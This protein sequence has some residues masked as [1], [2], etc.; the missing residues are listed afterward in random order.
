MEE[1]YHLTYELTPHPEGITKED[2]P[3]GHGA[4]DAAILCSIMYPPDG[5]YSLLLLPADGRNG[6]RLP[7]SEIFKVW[8]LMTKRLAESKT[9]PEPRRA[10]VEEIWGVIRAAVWGD[11]Q[12]ALLPTKDVAEA[13]DPPDV[14]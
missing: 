6:D 12:V 5:S 13:S 3:P 9:L 1:K 7:D 10:F 11:S 8:T 2:V 4:C 14:G